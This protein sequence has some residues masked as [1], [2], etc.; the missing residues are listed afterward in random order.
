MRLGTDLLLLAANALSLAAGALWLWVTAAGGGA[1]SPARESDPVDTAASQ[2]LRER[3][4]RSDSLAS[5][6]P[7]NPARRPPSP[8]AV[9]EAPPVEPP[10]LVG[11]VMSASPAA[12]LATATGERSGL[13]RAGQSFGGWTVL[14]VQSTRV[15]LRAGERVLDV[16]LRGQRQERPPPARRP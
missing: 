15:R 9:A 2:P 6:P 4:V 16:P 11:V 10:V 5:R 8:Q 14:S 13:L 7:F 3:E 12:L 1:P